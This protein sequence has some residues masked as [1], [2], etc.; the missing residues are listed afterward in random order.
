MVFFRAET[1][2]TNGPSDN[3][4]TDAD[5]D[6]DF[7]KQKPT[8]VHEEDTADLGDEELSFWEKRSIG[9]ANRPWTHCCS[10]F[11]IAFAIG[12]IGLIAGGFAV[13]VDGAGW[14]SRGTLISERH[15]QFSLIDSNAENLYNDQS[16]D[17][18]KN[19]IENTQENLLDDDDDGDRRLGE[20]FIEGAPRP[21]FDQGV[22]L[23]PSGKQ[24]ERSLPFTFT[25]A[26]DRRLQEMS[27]TGLLEGCDTTWYTSGM[28][29][30]EERIWPIWRLKKNK[31]TASFFEGE[32]LQELCEQENITQKYL[33]D[34]KLCFGCDSDDRCLQPYSPV[35]YARLVVENGMT[36]GCEELAQA[37]DIYK[38]SAE[39]SLVQC[40]V[41]MKADY[42]PERDGQNLPESCPVGFSPIM[43]DELYDTSLRVQYSSSV[44]A[45]TYADIDELYDAVDNYARGE[46]LVEGAYD[47]Q[48]EDFNNLSLDEQLVTDMTLA[49]AS[50][51]IT[52]AAMVFHTKSLFLALTGLL[53]IALSFPLAYTVY[54]FVAQLDFF[55]FLNFIGMPQSSCCSG[56]RLAKAVTTAHKISLSVA[57]R[58]CHF[59]PRCR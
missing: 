49:L 26:L 24:S 13:T 33:V 8:T 37:W 57:R 25:P 43:I 15:I 1:G 39:G 34:K 3:E 51:F 18:W 4:D 52:T 10:S 27:G 19:L 38:E 20:A 9:M 46:E 6:Y 42:Q 30:T 7:D 14:E 32:V 54:T 2:V 21:F 11:V 5:A 16:G 58:I 12:V 48:D 41:D 53:Q 55:P 35:F 47:T 23:Y 28:L 50:A 56:G 29:F 45:T 31:E 40:V 22:G 59:R 17:T 44:F 36:L